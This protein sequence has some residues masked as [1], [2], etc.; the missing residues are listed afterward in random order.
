[1]QPM[2]DQ[3]IDGIRMTGELEMV[4]RAPSGRVKR[5]LKLRNLV[6]TAGKGVIAER[7]KQTPSK[8]HMTHMAVG[9]GTTAAAA[10][11]TALQ[12]QISSRVALGSTTVST[13]TIT[14]ACTFGAGVSTGTISEA[15]IFN[16]SSGGDMLSR[17]VFTGF[18][19]GA[20]DSLAVSWVVTI[21]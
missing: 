16:A 11:D 6:V 7:M 12:T 5:R 1:M 10:G 3:I 17:V 4:L 21:N 18:T 8:G 20:G 14:Y 15:G 2:S 13:N 19:K 9:S